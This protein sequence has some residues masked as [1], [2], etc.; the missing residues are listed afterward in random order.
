MPEET[1]E[2]KILQL[3]VRKQYQGRRLDKYL[4]AR[5]QE[6]SRSFLQRLIKDGAVRVDGRPAKASYLIKKG[7][8]ITLELPVIEEEHV[9]PEPIP[10]DIIYEDDSLMLI[11]KP[12]DMV[13]HPAPG[14]MSGTLVNALAY[15][16]QRLSSTGGSLKPGIVHRLDR[17]TSGI[18]LVVKSELVHEDLARQFETRKVHKEYLALVEGDVELDSDVLELPIG[19]HKKDRLKMAIRHDQGKQATSIYEVVERF[20]DFTLLRVIPRTG[21][22]HQIRVHMRA[23][24]HPIVADAD[25]NNRDCLYRWEILKTEPRPEEPPLLDRQALHAHRLEF[26]HPVLKRR[27]S[28]QAE[29]PGDMQEVLRLLRERGPCPTKD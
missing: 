12:P 5:L 18:M 29:L 6:Y 14:H 28:F 27:M 25:Y 19:R 22:T 11:N 13:V 9:R 3:E 17:D 4:A 20:G 26:F 15:H 8:S 23:I 16:C 7:D 2:K 21:R 1:R 24:G 10:L